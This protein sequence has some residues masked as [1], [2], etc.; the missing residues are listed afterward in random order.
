MFDYHRKKGYADLYSLHSWCG[1]LVLVLYFLQVRLQPTV[2]GA[3]AGAEGGGDH[4]GVP[5]GPTSR[6]CA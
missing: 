6:P 4:T 3:G 1:L 5:S 2:M